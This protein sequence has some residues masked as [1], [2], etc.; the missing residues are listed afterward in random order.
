MLLAGD[1]RPFP[2]LSTGETAA[3]DL[4]GEC[5]GGKTPPQISR[6][7]NRMVLADVVYPEE[8]AEE[9]QKV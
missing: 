3:T 5:G 2:D 1:R 7:K 4:S 8:T 6:G 9:I